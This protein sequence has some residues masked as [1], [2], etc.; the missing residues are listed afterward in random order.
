MSIILL[1]SKGMWGIADGEPTVGSKQKKVT[2][3][4]LTMFTFAHIFHQL[5]QEQ[6]GCFIFRSEVKGYWIFYF[7]YII[8]FID[9]LR[10]CWTQTLIIWKTRIHWTDTLDGS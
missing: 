3:N 7:I 8:K 5:S 10:P 9:F 4:T 1:F 2:L 6:C